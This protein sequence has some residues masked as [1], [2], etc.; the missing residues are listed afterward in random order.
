MSRPS[1]TEKAEAAKLTAEA[2][3]IAARA[4]QIETKNEIA[5]LLKS[6]LAE[7]ATA[8]SGSPNVARTSDRV[9]QE[10]PLRRFGRGGILQKLAPTVLERFFA[11]NGGVVIPGEF[12][13]QDDEEAVV[14]CPCGEEPRVPLGSIRPCAGGKACK[15]VFFFTGKDVRSAALSDDEVAV[16]EAPAI[17]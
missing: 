15:R 5:A 11:Q 10:R 16:F 4:K 6:A 12:W 14:T 7:A 1:Q 3:E 13:I 8:V 2:R 17:A 9:G